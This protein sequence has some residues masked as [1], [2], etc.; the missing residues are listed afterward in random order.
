MSAQQSVIQK[1]MHSLDETKKQGTAALDEAVRACSQFGSYQDL[2]NHFISDAEQAGSYDSFLRN[3]CGIILDNEDTGAITGADAGGSVVKTAESIV[4]EPAGRVSWTYYDSRSDGYYV[5]IRGL[6][7]IVAPSKAA[8]E[9]YSEEETTIARGLCAWWIGGGLDLINASYG[10]SFQEQGTTVKKMRLLFQDDASSSY[11]AVANNRYNTATG[12]AV[13]LTLTVNLAYYRNIREGDVNG[14]GARNTTYLDR[15]IAHE[16]T[17]AVMAANINYFDSLPG[18]IKEGM[19]E[20]TH[21]ADDVRASDIRRLAQDPSAFQSLS[22]ASVWATKDVYAGGYM[23]LR[24]LAQQGAAGTTSGGTA[25]TKTTTTTPPGF[26]RLAD[27]T[28]HA[29]TGGGD[30]YIGAQ[31][32]STI[33]AGSDPAAMWG[34]G[35][36]S[37]TFIAGAAKDYYWIGAGDG[38]DR[39]QGF[40]KGTDTV[41]CW[42]GCQTLTLMASGDDLVVSPGGATLTLTGAMASDRGDIAILAPGMSAERSVKAGSDTMLGKRYDTLDASGYVGAHILVGGTDES[43]LYAGHG[44]CAMWGGGSEGDCLVGSKDNASYFWFGRGDGADIACSVSGKDTVYLWNVSDINAVQVTRSDET[45]SALRQTGSNYGQYTQL[46]LN[47]SDSLMVMST[48]TRP[49]LML[50]NGATY[51]LSEQGSGLS[52]TRIR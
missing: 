6:R 12:K 27:G 47:D 23:L 32:P 1:F 17:H 28:L 37:D 20:L 21:G 31:T 36:A 25:T 42:S 46:T 51:R 30:V 4:P 15:I 16:L 29:R 33:R 48:G 52:L 49:D 11:I 9:R 18:A 38:A 8:Y 14:E 34:G 50:A 19:A 5:D 13:D 39:V 40:K 24:Y 7:L 22:T 41:Y 2:V 3:S 43:F 26:D 10:M 45:E 44:A 35:A